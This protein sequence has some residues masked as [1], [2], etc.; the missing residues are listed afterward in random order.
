[1]IMDVASVSSEFSTGDVEESANNRRQRLAR[2]RK[3][4]QGAEGATSDNRLA[5]QRQRMAD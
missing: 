3:A 1:M 5:K 4:R 2:K